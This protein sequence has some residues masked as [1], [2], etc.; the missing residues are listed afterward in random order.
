MLQSGSILR[1]PHI[2]VQIQSDPFHCKQKKNIDFTIVRNSEPLFN[3]Y[4]SFSQSEKIKEFRTNPDRSQ[5]ANSFVSANTSANMA[6]TVL[7]S[8]TVHSSFT[9]AS[10]MAY[11]QKFQERACSAKKKRCFSQ[12]MC[13]CEG[14]KMTDAD[15]R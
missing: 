2:H 7:Y 12:R 9:G 15:R 4:K 8:D 10:V 5:R 13:N 1:C 3:T 11:F 6:K 14:A